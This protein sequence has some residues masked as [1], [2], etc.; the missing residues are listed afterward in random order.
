MLKPPTFT[1]TEGICSKKTD[2]GDQGSIGRRGGWGGRGARGGWLVAACLAWASPAAAQMAVGTATETTQPGS[3][4]NGTD[5]PDTATAQA[6]AATAAAIYALHE[7]EARDR[8]ALRGEIDALRAELAAERAA[9][10]AAE[11]AL[12]SHV[13]TLTAQS[14]Q[15]PPEVLTARLGLS[16]T[17]YLQADWTIANQLSQDQLNTAGV[18]LNQSEF[19]IRRA[20]LRAALERWWV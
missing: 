3:G 20:R 1:A 11:T 10:Q 15:A 19:M 5:G 4:A 17:G 9:R 2:R 16:L 8:A 18:P 14:S 7:Q 6:A 13:D 12:A